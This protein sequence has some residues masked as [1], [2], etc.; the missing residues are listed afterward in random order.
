ML[1][2]FVNTPATFQFYINK[3]LCKYL[4]VFVII[5]LNNIMIYSS[6]E[7]NYK[8]HIHAVLKALAKIDLYIKLFKCHFSVHEIDFLNY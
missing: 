1:F 2:D 8:K 4:D 6:C 3:I 5:Y 7:E